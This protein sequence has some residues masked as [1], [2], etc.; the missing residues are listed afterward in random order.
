[1]V[2]YVWEAVA[3]AEV[4]YTEAGDEDLEKFGSIDH[5]VGLE[6]LIR[7]AGEH[8]FIG[9]VQDGCFVPAA[10]DVIEYGSFCSQVE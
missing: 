1:M 3:T 9:Q 10:V 7:I 4:S 8:T 6:R 5:V 2:G